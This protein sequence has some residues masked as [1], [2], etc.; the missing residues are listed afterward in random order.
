M[1]FQKSSESELLRG[2][3][4]FQTR[5]NTITGH[6]WAL[7]KKKKHEN[8][9]TSQSGRKWTSDVEKESNESKKCFHLLYHNCRFLKDLTPYIEQGAVI[10]CQYSL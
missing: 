2:V 10:N 8:G 9:K 3:C 1:R 4:I 7:E 6:L 5:L